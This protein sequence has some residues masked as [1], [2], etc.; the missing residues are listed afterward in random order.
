MEEKVEKKGSVGAY[1]PK[2]IEDMHW[3]E[4]IAQKI[5]DTKKPPFVV[6]SGATTSGPAHLGTVCEFLYPYTIKEALEN[7]GFDAKVV[8]VADILDALD[9]VPYELKSK[10]EFISKEIGKPLCTAADPLGCHASFG[11]H[12][13]SQVEEAIEFLGV[14]IKVERADRLYLSGAFDNYAKIFLEKENEVKEI[15]AQTSGRSIDS[16]KDWSPIMPICQN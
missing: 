12:Y 4:I 14:D 7:L 6:T 3:A 1:T 10:E 5:V 8:F 2:S 15:I 11:E 16:L 13:L 9:S